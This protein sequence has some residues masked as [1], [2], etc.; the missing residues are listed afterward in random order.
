MDE[1]YNSLD[2]VDYNKELIVHAIEHLGKNKIDKKTGNVLI[3]LLNK[4]LDFIKGVIRSLRADVQSALSDDTVEISYKD[5]IDSLSY[6]ADLSAITNIL[7]MSKAKIVNTT[8]LKHEY[9]I[10]NIFALSESNM[11]SDVIPTA[12]KK[13][14]NR[15]KDIESYNAVIKAVEDGLEITMYADK[16][17]KEGSGYSYYGTVEIDSN[18]Y[19]LRRFNHFD[20]FEK[21]GY[22]LDDSLEVQE[23][24]NYKSRQQDLNA[25]VTF[26]KQDSLEALNY[27]KGVVTEMV[28]DAAVGLNNLKTDKDIYTDFINQLKADGFDEAGMDVAHL[29]SLL[30]SA[31]RDSAKL[32]AQIILSQIKSNGLM[33]NYTYI[34]DRAFN[35]L[36]NRNK[37]SYVIPP[38]DKPRFSLGKQTSTNISTLEFAPLFSK[39]FETKKDDLSFSLFTSDDILAKNEL[40]DLA[41]KLSSQLQVPFALVDKPEAK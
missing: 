29:E 23:Y 28:K 3:N 15:Q 13:L 35:R 40:L 6:S 7:L 24:S 34:L 20:S 1:S 30:N 27:R 41:T 21:T 4:F 32:A 12:E 5:L 25:P 10:E 33:G 37:Y 17:R 9:T 31:D 36:D 14:T 19:T 8:S 39:Q 16:D 2:E 22:E 26:T 11:K 38:S 18:K